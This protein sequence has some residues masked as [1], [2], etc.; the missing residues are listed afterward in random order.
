M[1]EWTWIHSKSVICET[2]DSLVRAHRLC[3]AVDLICS[4][5]PG[6]THFP[7]T[8]H[9]FAFPVTEHLGFVLTGVVSDPSSS[10]IDKHEDRTVTLQ[11]VLHPGPVLAS[12]S[13]TR[14][15]HSLQTPQHQ[16]VPFISHPGTHVPSLKVTR[17]G[18]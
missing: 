2:L 15:L 4:V 11:H 7:R 12:L 18:C 1:N 16:R 10:L 13:L 17:L 9:G 6:L 14:S 5:Y 3:F 8:C